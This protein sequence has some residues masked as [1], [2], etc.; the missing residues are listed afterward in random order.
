MGFN[1][2]KFTEKLSP[3]GSG[4]STDAAVEMAAENVVDELGLET[5]F[6]NEISA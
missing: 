5:Q 1:P 2:K 4:H 6:F 3:E